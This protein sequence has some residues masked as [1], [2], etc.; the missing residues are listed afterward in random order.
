MRAGAPV[1]RSWL[2]SCE[3][4]V[5]RAIEASLLTEEQRLRGTATAHRLERCLC[6]AGQMVLPTTTATRPW[7]CPTMHA[8]TAERTPN[9]D[10]GLRTT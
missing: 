5:R 1:R 6:T 9:Q 3:I 10:D 7:G 4:H 8:W 2:V